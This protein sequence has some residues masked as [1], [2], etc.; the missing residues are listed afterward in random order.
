V[1]DP[2]A[3]LPRLVAGRRV[4]VV[5]DNAEHLREAAAEV[6][7]ALLAVDGPRVLVTSRERLGLGEETAY[8]VPPLAPADGVALF[9]SRARRHDPAFAPDGAVAELC[10]RL[11]WL[12]LALELA[13]ARTSLFS[14][15]GLLERLGERLDLLDAGPAADPRQR[16]LRATTEWSVALLDEAQLRTF[17]RLSAFAADAPWEAVEPVCESTPDALLALVERSLVRRRVGDDGRP[18]FGM[19]ETVRQLAD[20]ELAA[21]PAEREACRG[22]H[23]TTVV[24]RGEDAV[25]GAGPPPVLRLEAD[26]ADLMHA[27]RFARERGEADLALRAT[28]V[29]HRLWRLRGPYAEGVEAIEA[30]LGLGG[31]LAERGRGQLAL[32]DLVSLQGH[33][34]RGLE[35][36]EEARAT[37]E[38]AG[39]ARTEAR[40]L[41]LLGNAAFGTRD[42]PAAIVYYERGIEVLVPGGDSADLLAPLA[43]LG[44]AC[45]ELG[46]TARARATLEDCLARS[47]TIGDRQRVSA[48]LHS[49]GVLEL[50]EE[51]P[52]EAV[53]ALR[54]GLGV[55]RELGLVKYQIDI[56]AVAGCALV[57]LG[58]HDDGMRVLGAAEAHARAIGMTPDPEGSVDARVRA[59]A[60]QA[61]MKALGPARYD[62]AYAAG[63]A[64]PLERVVADVLRVPARA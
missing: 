5:L 3:A 51:R 32:A 18:R 23:A 16:T 35:L 44:H 58:E 12:P 38:R 45:I 7:A 24:A 27:M 42:M 56:L 10:A 41:N 59:D 61:A 31:S 4:L 60:V 19:L 13:A 64:E 6:A 53:E 30:A 11:D 63:R 25:A 49:L 57:A 52:A 8:A 55:A 54:A 22:R 29:L 1:A 47:A 46:E 50:L 40:A 62:A 28:A 34:A 2:L 26:R 20:E 15:A 39:D 33:N 14:P 36:A 17:R 21:D 37:A 43:N 48:C 9:V